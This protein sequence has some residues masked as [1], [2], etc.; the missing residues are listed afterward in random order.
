M[1]IP[2]PLR[3]PSAGVVSSRAARAHVIGVDIASELLAAATVRAEIA[4]RTYKHALNFGPGAGGLG[5]GRSHRR[6]FERRSSLGWPARW[7]LP[8]RYYSV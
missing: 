4:A 8:M 2:L 5:H 1:S 6:F 3:V 7:G